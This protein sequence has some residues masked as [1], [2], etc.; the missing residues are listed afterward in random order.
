[1]PRAHMYKG[2]NVSKAKG[3]LKK[4]PAESA[5]LTGGIIAGAIIQAFELPSKWSALLTI[6]CGLVAPLVT[7]AVERWGSARSSRAEIK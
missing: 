2:V 4:R 7:G 1:M 3:I 5:S 6:V